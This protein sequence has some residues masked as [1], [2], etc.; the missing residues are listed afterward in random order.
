MMK[1]FAAQ[2]KLYDENPSIFDM[3]KRD[4]KAA[5]KKK[6]RRHEKDSSSSSSSSS[7]DNSSD[8]ESDV[9]SWESDLIDDSDDDRSRR[10]QKTKKKSRKYKRELNY[11]DDSDDSSSQDEI[12]GSAYDEDDDEL[13]Q[14][15]A[16]ATT[17]IAQMNEVSQW[18]PA[19]IPKTKSVY[20]INI[21][22]SKPTLLFVKKARMVYH[23]LRF[24]NSIKR[25]HKEKQNRIQETVSK[26]QEFIANASINCFDNLLQYI[27]IPITSLINEQGKNLD[28]LTSSA[29]TSGFLSSLFSR[30]SKEPNPLPSKLQKQVYKVCAKVK[31]LLDGVH[32][33]LTK[34]N[35][36]D[37][38]VRKR[39]AKR[40]FPKVVP[41]IQLFSVL[42]QDHICYPTNYLLP[43]ELLLLHLDHNGATINM[44][45]QRSRV[46]LGHFI[47]TRIL[48]GKVLVSR[49]ESEKTKTNSIG[50]TY[51]KA[52]TRS[53]K[54][55]R[56][57]IFYALELA[58]RPTS[59]DE[60]F[61][62]KERSSGTSKRTLDELL[63]DSDSIVNYLI[64]QMSLQVDSPH[65]K[66]PS[67]HRY[68]GVYTERKIVKRI[69]ERIGVHSMLHYES[70]IR[71][72]I[73]RAF[74]AT[75]NYNRYD[76]RQLPPEQSL[77]VWTQYRRALR[78]EKT[79]RLRHVDFVRQ[80]LIKMEEAKALQRQK[81]QMLNISYGTAVL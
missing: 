14:L 25:I 11:N 1:K 2:K 48:L 20:T 63:S 69:I 49:E 71:N 9:D 46:L 66:Y 39:S 59:L 61:V 37:K 58:L 75:V 73:I 41:M 6:K 72:I 27:H 45:K 35:L 68:A 67:N 57:I 56:S 7:S 36:M 17:T 40:F 22:H 64:Q 47:I 34:T 81:L 21:D 24:L 23:M 19:T 80:Q 53:L 50:I 26:M 77:K 5:K 10:K 16:Q 8:D 29:Q 31:A 38:N 3:D 44:S 55:I 62:R 60:D 51:G 78:K 30:G 76:A 79:Q 4:K 65:C 18:E 28:F 12:E 33:M 54:L 74:N 70:I 15:V 43:S 52:C 42:V 13:D 32:T